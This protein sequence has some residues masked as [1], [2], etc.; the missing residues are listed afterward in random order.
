MKK[1]TLVCH[2]LELMDCGC[3]SEFVTSEFDVFANTCQQ[4]VDQMPE[5]WWF[6]GLWLIDEEKDTE[7]DVTEWF[8][9]SDLKDVEF[10]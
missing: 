2:R 10:E 5:D 9:N 8:R 6:D 3:C 1:F 4:A 7:T